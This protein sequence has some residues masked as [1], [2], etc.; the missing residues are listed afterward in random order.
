MLKN[1]LYRDG[2]VRKAALYKNAL[3]HGVMFFLRF[4][5]PLRRRQRPSAA[6]GSLRAPLTF[7]SIWRMRRTSAPRARNSLRSCAGHAPP[8]PAERLF[9]SALC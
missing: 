4:R 7:C 5:S 3:P 2:F 1:L 9:C 6:T 8:S